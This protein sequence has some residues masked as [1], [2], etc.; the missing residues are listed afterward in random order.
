MRKQTLTFKN[1]PEVTGFGTVVG[2]KEGKGPMK[3][4]FDISLEEDT[5]GEKTWEKSESKM[6]KQSILLAMLKSGREK[7]DID[8]LL[9]GDLLNQIMSSSF[10]ARDLGIPFLGLYGACSAM[11]ES[12]LIGASF[13]NGGM[14]K[15]AIGG[16]SSHYCTAERQFRMPLE[17]GNQRPPT[18]QWTCT[19]AGA[20]CISDSTENN[21]VESNKNI[22]SNNIYITH[23]TIG[24][25]IDTGVKDSNQMGAAMAPA[26]VDTIVTHLNE[27][28]RTPDFYDVILTGDLGNIGKEIVIDLLSGMNVDLRKNYNDCGD[29]MFYKEQDC[30]S[31]GSGCGCSASIFSGYVMKEMRHGN[32]NNALILSTGAL[33]STISAQQGES[34]PGIA[35]AI[36]LTTNKEI[37]ERG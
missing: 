20:V 33:L 37:M 13:V 21:G 32:I 34:I 18:A 31:G 11:T 19:A 7:E 23:G 4:W 26:A 29:M 8:L 17:H 24:K 28:G 1:M 16:A 14:I 27:T 3:K 22:N 35:H 9:T 36:A 25:I 5:F 15:N 10:M 6:L 30:H 12:M 2:E